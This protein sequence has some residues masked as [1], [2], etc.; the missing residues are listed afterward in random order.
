MTLAKPGI[1]VLGAGSWGTALAMLLARN[2]YPVWLWG[3]DPAHMARLA[4]ERTNA[5]FLP[6]IPF[7]DSLTTLDRI[8]AIPAE[9]DR[10]LLVVPSHAFRICL[11]LLR[12]RINV[13]S[14]VVWATKGLEPVTSRLLSEVADE[15]LGNSVAKAVVSGPTFAGE[16]ARNLPTALVVASPDMAVARDVLQWFQG[17]RVRAYSNTDIIGVQLGAALKNVMAIAAGISDGLG[18]GAN[19]RAALITRGLAE[20]SRLGM[21]LGGRRETFDGL[22]G[23]GDLVLTCTD[24]QSRNRRFGLGLGQ[25][26]K[27]EEILAELGQEVE[28]IGTAK[29]AYTLSQR[30]DIEMPISE[31]VYRVLNDGLAPQEAVQN[32][33]SRDPRAES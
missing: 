13:E 31:Q 9:I 11:D 15:V 25:G 28:G 14:Q 10:Y 2:G 18:F 4:E 29:E 33:L 6:G 7:P 12:P 19:A 1:A 22:T 23:L 8:A 21:A 17:E 3:H 20:L 32:L 24:N 5:E 26:R 30:Y 16:V 27:R